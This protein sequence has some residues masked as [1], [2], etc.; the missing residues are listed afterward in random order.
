MKYI[1][2]EGTV[3]SVEGGRA[4]VRLDRKV[5]ESCGTCC[6]CS[7]HQNGKKTIEVDA[8]D[9]EDGDRVRARI[10]RVNPYLSMFLVFG[11]PLALFMTG[12]MVGQR[13][14]GGERLGTASAIGGIVGLMVAMLFALL[15]NHLLTRNAHPEARKISSEKA[16]S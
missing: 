4:T 1:E 14:Q 10:P 8:N 5:T 6:A 11:L 16:D 9:L 7:A 12:I 13:V 2:E 15:M 3:V